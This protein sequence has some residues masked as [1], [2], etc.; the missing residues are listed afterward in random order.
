VASDLREALRRLTLRVPKGASG[1]EATIEVTSRFQ[2]PSGY[3]PVTEVS[4]LG[5]PLKRA[6]PTAKQ[7]MRVELLK[8]QLSIADVAPP[9]DSNA[10]I[11]LPRGPHVEAAVANRRAKRQFYG[12]L[13]TT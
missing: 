9:P 5:V 12:G 7:P 11:K 1:V 2:L 4:V 6:P 8:P 10:P 3:D 13:T